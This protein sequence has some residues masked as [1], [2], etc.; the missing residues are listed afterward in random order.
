MVYN[1]SMKYKNFI[2]IF[3][4]FSLGFYLNSCWRVNYL[5]QD[6]QELE[7]VINEIALSEN[8]NINNIKEYLNNKN[9][10][11]NVLNKIEYALNEYNIKENYDKMDQD[12]KILIVVTHKSQKGLAIFKKEVKYLMSITF[13]EDNEIKWIMY[14]EINN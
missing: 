6:E 4:I 7:F 13:N 8:T 5:N 10:E 14:N 9:I 3:I 1:K 2:I 11:Y 12:D